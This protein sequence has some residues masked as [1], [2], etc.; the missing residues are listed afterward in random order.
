MLVAN[1]RAK[2]LDDL[3]D[4]FTPEQLQCAFKSRT[5]LNKLQKERGLKVSNGDV[6]KELA[7]VFA[8]RYM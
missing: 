1:K 5:Q 2:Q 4:A 7:A 3:M 6:Y 8:A